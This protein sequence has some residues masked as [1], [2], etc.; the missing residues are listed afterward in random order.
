MRP[1]WQKTV[2]KP[3]FGLVDH[4]HGIQESAVPVRLAPLSF[5]CI[6]IRFKILINSFIF[7]I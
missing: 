7:L 2:K 5:L 1:N 6:P 4:L 3:S